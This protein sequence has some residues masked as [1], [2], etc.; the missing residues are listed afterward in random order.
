MNHFTKILS[1]LIVLLLFSYTAF[2]QT[3]PNESTGVLDQTNFADTLYIKATFTECGEFG[4]HIELLKVY[5]TASAFNMTYQKFGADCNKIE[6]NQGVPA[7]ILNKTLT[8]KLTED[9]NIAIE[10][11]FEQLKDAAGNKDD[12]VRSG[13][14]FQVIKKDKDINLAIYTMDYK[15]RQEYLTLID[16][17]TH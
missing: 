11:Y 8:R 15:I 17:V 7:Q 14:T 6:E 9:D 16:K 5:L 13:Y 3:P 10:Y 12:Y 1:P 4:G 2:G